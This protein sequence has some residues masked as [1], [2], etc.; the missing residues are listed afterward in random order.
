MVEMHNIVYGA[1]R[2]CGID[3]P[4]RCFFCHMFLARLDEE[5]KCPFSQQDGCA[6]ALCAGCELFE[7]KEDEGYESGFESDEN[8]P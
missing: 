1:C 6:Y 3:V 5:H 8:Q 7:E 4:W 2:G